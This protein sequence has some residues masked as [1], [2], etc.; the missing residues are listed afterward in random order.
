MLESIG[1]FF[2]VAVGAYCSAARQI[3]PFSA[4]KRSL[5]SF[6]LLYIV[7]VSS[8]PSWPGT[9]LQVLFKPRNSL[10][11]CRL[12]GKPKTGLGDVSTY[13]KSMFHATKQIYLIWLPS[14]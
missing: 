7:Y 10:V 6:A 11:K 9:N 4:V 3:H 12:F 8:Q 13:S 14:P 2:I 5:L 1:L